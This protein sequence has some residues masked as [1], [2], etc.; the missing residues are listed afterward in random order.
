[1]D[2]I[3]QMKEFQQTE[4]DERKNYMQ[5]MDLTRKENEQ[6]TDLEQVLIDAY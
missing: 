3:K 5:M 2:E 1:M 6:L 4:A